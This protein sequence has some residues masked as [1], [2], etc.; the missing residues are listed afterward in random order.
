MIE[1]DL[2]VPNKLGLH[3]RA[4]AKLV[5]LASRRDVTLTLSKNG[6]QWVDARNIMGILMLGA[7]KGTPLNFRIE[8]EE[9]EP[10]KDEL[11]ALFERFF[12]EPQ[13]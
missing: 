11:E 2:V 8:G 7:K 13:D 9:S 6:T 10:A 5:S 1:L 4:A 3:A 12:D